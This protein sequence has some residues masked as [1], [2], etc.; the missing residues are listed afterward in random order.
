MKLFTFSMLIK[1]HLKT[2]FCRPGKAPVMI[3]TKMCNKYTLLMNF[4]TIKFVTGVLPFIGQVL[5][6]L[7][8]TK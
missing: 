6:L 3:F 7:F 1:C 4:R 8:G 5:S 2:I